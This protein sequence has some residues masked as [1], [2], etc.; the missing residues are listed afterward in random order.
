MSICS[1][2][3]GY[4]R[5]KRRHGR[6]LLSDGK[7]RSSKT[8]KSVKVDRSE[9]II[10]IVKGFSFPLW[11]QPTHKHVMVRGA[12]TFDH[13]VTHLY[14][15]IVSRRQSI[16]DIFDI[17]TASRSHNTANNRAERNKR[18]NRP[19]SCGTADDATSCHLWSFTW[20]SCTKEKKRTVFRT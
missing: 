4:K 18:A 10:S 2:R 1:I 20:P 15:R 6:F 13:A 7:T 11:V 3:L 8:R 12:Q 19:S 14:F 9:S 16:F 17:F 5:Y